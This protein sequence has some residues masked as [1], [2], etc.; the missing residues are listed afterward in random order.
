[1]IRSLRIILGLLP[2]LKFTFVMSKC[3]ARGP[4]CMPINWSEE[5]RYAITNIETKFKNSNIETS[6]VNFNMHN[7]GTWT[8]NTI[9][10]FFVQVGHET[11]F[12]STLQ[13]FC[14]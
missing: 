13:M 10:D 4:P 6:N 11:T 5:P 9:Q 8:V 1:M 3:M 12:A 14:M 2:L 7:S